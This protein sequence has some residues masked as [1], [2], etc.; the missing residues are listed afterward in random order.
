MT[1]P[2][3]TPRPRIVPQ[4]AA[5]PPRIFPVA[6]AAGRAAPTMM[7]SAEAD[8]ARALVLAI[9]KRIEGYLEEETTALEKSA[10]FD[11]KSSNDRK[12]QGL[13]DLNQAMRR[14]RKGDVNADL[15]T[16][17]SAFRGKLDKNLTTIRL[18]MN[19][20]KEIAAVLSEAIQRSDSDGTYTRRNPYRHAP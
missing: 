1:A 17:A 5:A 20:A 16:R 19:A 15:K 4:P 7:A 2:P 8:T 10:D 9:I 11:F 13:V 14:L 3:F 18:H 6:P 12:S